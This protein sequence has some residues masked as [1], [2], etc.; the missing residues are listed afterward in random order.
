MTL[1]SSDTIFFIPLGRALKPVKLL[2]TAHELI[3]MRFLL[4]L[5]IR[6]RQK[7]MISWALIILSHTSEIPLQKRDLFVPYYTTKKTV[8]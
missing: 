1:P 7:A 6:Q 5:Y 3:L 2:K 4:I 8:V